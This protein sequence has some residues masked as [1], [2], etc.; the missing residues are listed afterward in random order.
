MLAPLGDAHTG[1]SCPGHDPFDG[2]RPGTRD[3]NDVAR[4]AATKAVDAHLR[5]DL[6]VRRIHTF[7]NGKI[8]Y[9]DLPDGRGYLRL[10]AFENLGHDHDSPYP[11]GT[12]MTQALDAI[13][14][15]ERVESW[16]ELVIDLRWNSGGDD[17]LGIQLAGRLTDAPY[18]AYTKQA[19][20]DPNDPMRY[21]PPITVPVTP[22]D[23]PRY[24]GPVRLLTSDLTVSAGETF[25]EAM[26][27]RSP[28]PSRVGMTTQ[29]VF[30]DD[31]DRKLTNGCTFSLG[32][33]NYVAAN[34]TSYEGIGI[35]PTI[36]T[37]VFT[38]AELA[39]HRDSALD[40]PGISDT[41]AAGPQT[42]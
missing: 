10:T 42:R 31:M 14:T 20:I 16:R 39:G 23:G 24:T 22:A 26:M 18:T 4:K 32:N 28:A 2:K 13:F 36:Q 1:I 17:P 33:E 7:G 12:A 35:P 30:S 38:P 8:A 40:T 21:G 6:G 11:N 34:G 37:P 29:G 15:Q 5:D 3:E 41:P 9:A 19:R 25:V 27:G